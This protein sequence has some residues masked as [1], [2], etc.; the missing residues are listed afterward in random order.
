MEGLYIALLFLVLGALVRKFPNLIAGYGSL[1][2][3]EKENAIY[4]GLSVY[5]SWIFFTMSGLT[6]IA[7]VVGIL[8]DRPN[9]GSGVGLIVTLLG[10]VVLII[11]GNMMVQRK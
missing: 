3:K 7:Y 8:I 2:Q 11:V 4:N 1:S 6:L 5:Y 10:A 9:L